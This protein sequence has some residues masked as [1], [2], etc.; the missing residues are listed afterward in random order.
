[1]LKVLRHWTW[2]SVKTKWYHQI[3][4]YHI[5]PPSHLTT[6]SLWHLCHHHFIRVTHM[7][8]AQI[9]RWPSKTGINIWWIWSLVWRTTKRQLTSTKLSNM[10]KMLQQHNSISSKP[11]NEYDCYDLQSLLE[12]LQ[13]G[14]GRPEN[15]H[16]YWLNEFNWSILMKY[17]STG[18][19]DI[20]CVVR[21]SFS[22]ASWSIREY[23]LS[24]FSIKRGDWFHTFF[25]M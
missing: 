7:V 3:P 10:C 23:P 1:M 16:S 15:N 24:G 13:Q 2:L 9:E 8:S 17:L 4:Y 6:M 19:V 14:Q 22:V 11:R 20:D 18:S 12:Q 25:K 5:K 21:C